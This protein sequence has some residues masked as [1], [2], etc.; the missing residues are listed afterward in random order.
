M[1]KIFF[2]LGLISLFAQNIFA[3]TFTVEQFQRHLRVGM[4]KDPVIATVRYPKALKDGE[5][6]VMFADGFDADGDDVFVEWYVNGRLF[7]IQSERPYGIRVG[8]DFYGHLPTKVTVAVRND[9]GDSSVAKLAITT[10]SLAETYSCTFKNGD[11]VVSV[12]GITPTQTGNTGV[13]LTFEGTETNSSEKAQVTSDLVFS[14]TI[15]SGTF[16]STIG[17][18][19]QLFNSVKGSVTFAADGVTVSAISV[20]DTET[21]ATLECS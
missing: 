1:R 20:E 7:T 18:T 13:N 17:S 9:Y 6:I 4:G 2:T 15:A 10:S 5:T 8:P 14:D 12:T 19:S 16:T 3:E 21:S 11:S